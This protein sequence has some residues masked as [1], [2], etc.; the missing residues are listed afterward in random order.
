M[1]DGLTLL[2]ERTESLGEG[3]KL[4]DEVAAMRRLRELGWGS[5][6]IARE[7][8]CSRET[9]R[10]WLEKGTWRSY[11]RGRGRPKKLDGLD[12]W[13]AEKLRQ[14]RGNAD[15]VRQDLEREKGIPISLRTLERSVA[16]LRQELLAEARA[17]VRFETAPGRQL[18]VDFW[19]AAAANR[20]RTRSAVFVRSDARLLA[21]DLCTGLPA[22]T[23]MGVVCRHGRCVPTL[24]RAPG[25]GAVR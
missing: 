22:R 16:H 8:R 11:R 13:L 17:T 21:A 19:R 24:R 18:Q 1:V 14:H 2:P 23:A 5:R 10:R 9:V 3:M 15:V 6:R 12:T 7:L 20:R 25:R 4:P